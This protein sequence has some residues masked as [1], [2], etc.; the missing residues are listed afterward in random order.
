[1]SKVKDIDQ[2]MPDPVHLFR[3]YLGRSD[4]HPTV[5]LHGVCGDDLTSDGCCKL[6]GQRGLA[7]RGRTG[8][9]YQSGSVHFI[10]I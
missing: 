1:M 10:S 6:C 7:D 3:P 2:V 8:Q 9:D 4:I 5:D